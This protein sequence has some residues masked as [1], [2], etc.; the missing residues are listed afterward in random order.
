MVRKSLGRSVGAGFVIGV[1]FSFTIVYVFGPATKALWE[2][3]IALWP[4]PGWVSGMAFVFWLSALPPAGVTSPG[5][6]ART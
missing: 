3:L 1:A 5:E 4:I 2:V 6:S